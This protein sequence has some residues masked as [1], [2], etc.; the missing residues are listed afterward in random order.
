MARAIAD[1]EYARNLQE[2]EQQAAAY[3]RSPVNL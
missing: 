3:G 1:E 2:E